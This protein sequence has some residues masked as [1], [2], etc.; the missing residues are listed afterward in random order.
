MKELGLDRPPIDRNK[1]WKKWL[2]TIAL[3][4]FGLYLIVTAVGICQDYRLRSARAVALEAVITDVETVSRGDDT[5]YDVYVS[6]TY[7]GKQY[8]ECYL[9]SLDED[10]K[11]KIGNSVTIVVDSL[12]PEVQIDDLTDGL[13]FAF[14]FGTP[15]FAVG[16]YTIGVNCR[17]DYTLVYGRTDEALLADVIVYKRRR[18]LWV[19][20]WVYT[21]GQIVWG[22]YILDIDGVGYGAILLSCMVM[23][24]SVISLVSYIRSQRNI[25][26]TVQKHV[27]SS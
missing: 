2:L 3:L 6:Y 23:P 21:I 8:R 19:P 5:D 22:I 16:C 4:G 24:F 7:D 11:N 9:S 10:W 26:E 20:L 18:I 12:E 15:I 14:F 25:T 1:A 27:K 17:Y 13:F